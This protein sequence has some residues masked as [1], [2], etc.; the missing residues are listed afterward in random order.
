MYL[1]GNGSLW[2]TASQDAQGNTIAN[3]SPIQF[4]ELQDVGFDFGRD[5]KLLYGNKAMPVA[6]AGGKMKF[7]FKSKFARVSGRIFNDLYFG[8]TMT[9]GTLAA[10]YN[11][12]Q[13]AAIPA[14]TPWQLTAMPPAT[15][16]WVRDLGCIDKNGQP[17][18]RVASA[19][20]T[21]QYSVGAGGVYTFATAD[22]GQT[23]YISYAYTAAVANAKKI[24]LSNQLMGA[25][26]VFGIDL[27]I[28]FQGK[29]AALS[30][31]NCVS[32][33]LSFDPK[34]DDFTTASMDFSAFT[35]GAGN[36]G[37]LSLSE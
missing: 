33:K 26:P 2:G 4:G 28:T 30:F 16:T 22:A 7:D 25:T 36:I 20:A 31:P 14:S 8:A 3:P 34:Q 17:M 13:G 12:L 1:F 21:G 35:D 18:S 27:G 37:Y 19:P 32:G 9:A 11:D 15:G 5:L 24:A 6:V 29:Q 10:V 23:V